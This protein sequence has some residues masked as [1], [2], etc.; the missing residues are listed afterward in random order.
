MANDRGVKLCKAKGQY[1]ENRMA[2]V[3]MSWT[4]FRDLYYLALSGSSRLLSRYPLLLVRLRLCSTVQLGLSL[5]PRELDK[6]PWSC[7]DSTGFSIP[8]SEALLM[9]RVERLNSF[10]NRWEGLQRDLSLN[11]Y[12]GNPSVLREDTSL[13]DI[14]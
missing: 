5:W 6:P 4:V 1:T 3:R 12:L 9:E 7:E 14:F 13:G 2:N 11:T 10:K 8:S